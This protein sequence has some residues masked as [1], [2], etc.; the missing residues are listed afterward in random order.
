MKRILFLSVLFLAVLQASAQNVLNVHSKTGAVI[1]GDIDEETYTVVSEL[2]IGAG[3]YSTLQLGV[4]YGTVELP[5]VNDRTVTANEVDDENRY[6]LTLKDVPFGDVYYRSFVK[7][8]GV[9]HYGE[10]KSFTKEMN[11]DVNGHDYV[12]LGLPCGT[13]WATCNVGATSPEEYGD[14]FA[15]GETQ[16]KSDY[17]WNTYKY[18]NGSY[19]TMTKYCTDSSY[20][21]VDNK[22]VLAPE[23]DAAHVNWGGDWR[24]PTQTEFDEL[25]NGCTWTWTA[26]NGV[27][28]YKVVSKTNGNFIFLPAAGYRSDT[29]LNNAGSNGDYWSSSLRA[30]CPNYEWNLYFGSGSRLTFGGSRYCGRSVRPVCP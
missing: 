27:N 19:T 6:T 18:C 23:D 21:T 25:L 5:T 13:L 15:W 1:T 29:Y 22:T 3:A 17:S 7:I 10:V 12:D 14:Y 16:P 24:M 28:G 20:G 4:C 26:L 11:L 9:A 8:D 2:R 30:D